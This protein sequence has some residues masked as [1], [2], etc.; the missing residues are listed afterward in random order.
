M[1]NLLRDSDQNNFID[2]NAIEQIN[3]YVV[4]GSTN[5]L[6]RV[7]GIYPYYQ[8]DGTTL[9]LVTDSS[10]VLETANFNSFV[11]VSSGHNTGV[12]MR[13]KQIEN[14]MW[15]SNGSDSVFVWNRSTTTVMDGKSYSDGVHPLVPKYKY[16]N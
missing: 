10:I 6:R 1:R 11:F 4:A 5:T 7:E 13:C 14:K 3:G 16:G 9:F 15:C 12:M 2:N 8:E